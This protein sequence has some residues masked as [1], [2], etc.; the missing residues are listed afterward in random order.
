MKL[1]LRRLIIGLTALVAHAVFSEDTSPLRVESYEIDFG[2]VRST[3]EP[4]KE[5]EISNIGERSIGLIRATSSCGCTK[6]ELDP[7][8]L[9]AGT[10]AKLHLSL[11]LS[12]YSSDKVL[13]HVSVETNDPNHPVL[14]IT[15]RANVIREYSVTP[16]SV[17]FGRVKR[18]TKPTA[19]LDFFQHYGPEISI[20]RIETPPELSIT[21]D[22]ATTTQEQAFSVPRARIAITLTPGKLND[23]YNSRFTLVTDSK[24]L[25]KLEIPVTAEIVGVEY[26]IMPK[27]LVFRPISTIG[28]LGSFL[29]KATGP[30]TGVSGTTD[31]LAITVR[32]EEMESGKQFKVILVG[33]AT[34][35]PGK[36]VGKVKLV[37]SEGDLSDTRDV[38]YFGTITP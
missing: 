5:I 3:D 20:L 12:D 7:I 33:S 8:D 6:A 14:Q 17:D 29:V 19:T 15:V 13:S 27:V 1:K 21:H 26:S 11:L 16:I 36:K 34:L 23:R 38:P 9:K 25:P 31:D 30:I 24:R 32:V 35:S 18:N 4:T 10:S 37:V 28:D 22:V 2:D